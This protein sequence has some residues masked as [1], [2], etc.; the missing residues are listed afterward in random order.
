MFSDLKQRVNQDKFKLLDNAE[1]CSET[2]LLYHLMSGL[3]TSV[4][5]HISEAFD[6]L[7]KPGDL[8]NN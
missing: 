2:T 5:T 7:E 4:N 1:S 6:D 8:V 3:H